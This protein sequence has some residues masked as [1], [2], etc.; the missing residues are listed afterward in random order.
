MIRKV[1]KVFLSAFFKNGTERRD[2][3][4]IYDRRACHQNGVPA[5]SAVPGA[6]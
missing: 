1:R 6:K 2:Q 5:H 3:E 4:S